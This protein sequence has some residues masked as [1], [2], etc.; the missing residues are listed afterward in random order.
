MQ[1]LGFSLAAQAQLQVR[2]AKISKN[3]ILLF[4]DSLSTEPVAFNLVFVLGDR[5]VVQGRYIWPDNFDTGKSSDDPDAWNLSV[6]IH[7]GDLPF[8]KVEI[9]PDDPNVQVTY[10][11]GCGLEKLFA[12][13]DKE[14]AAIFFRARNRVQNRESLLFACW[15]ILTHGDLDARSR[16]ITSVIF[17]YKLLELG[18]EAELAA[19][20]PR[21][22]AVIE[23]AKQLPRRGGV[24]TDGRMLVLSGLTAR[25]H[26][27]LYLGHWRDVVAVLDELV[28]FVEEMRPRPVA[29]IYNS[30]RGVAF[31]ALLAF[32]QRSSD[33]ARHLCSLNFKLFK[34][35]AHRIEAKSEVFFGEMIRSGPAVQL[36]LQIHN[37]M[38]SDGFKVDL[39]KVF[40]NIARIS[41]DDERT[42]RHLL[43]KAISLQKHM[44]QKP[45]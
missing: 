45:L 36:C 29:A 15:Q 34:E 19:F 11:P 5:R 3:R 39:R 31:R 21:L 24:R 7:E 4:V 10:A 42:Y 27:E 40:P 35:A 6:A 43:G 12:R 38:D 44:G 17:T 9:E 2:R 18:M 32:E 37:K 26:G 22:S 20:M 8:E 41:V 25:W 1:F 13:N 30:S 28:A 14:F 23:E 33:Q 16:M